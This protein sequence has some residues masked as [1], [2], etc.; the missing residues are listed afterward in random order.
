MNNLILP[1]IDSLNPYSSARDEFTGKAEI[2]LDANENSYG[3]VLSQDLSRYPESKHQTVR[4]LYA[5]YFGLTYDQ[6]FIGH[7]SDEAIDLLFR[8]S[9][10]AGRDSIIVAKPTYGMYEVSAAIHDIKVVK[11]PLDNN[12]NLDLNGFKD[13]YTANTK[14]TF[15]CSP[16]NPT[17]NCVPETA[18]L[19]LLTFATGLVVVDEA[20]IDFCGDKSCLKL[21]NQFPSLVVLRTLSKAWGCAGIRLGF[22]LAGKQII[23]ALMKVKAP[24]NISEPQL[25]LSVEAFNNADKMKNNAE[26]IIQNRNYLIDQL[27]KI[28]IVQK[29]YPSEANF[30]LVKFDNGNLRYKQLCDNGIIVRN[31]HKEYNCGDCLRITVGTE[32]ENQLL[33][34]CLTGLSN[35]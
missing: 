34:D 16:N 26:K 4:N 35:L 3:G 5:D 31:R 18:L 20:Y 15:I 22:A 6:I 1:H 11:V 10:Y 25:K 24:Y 30:I 32:V 21:I 9:C 29:V 33:L 12:F 14:I 23:N 17:G 7:G 19:E 28:S 27:I 8:I 13:K 2:N